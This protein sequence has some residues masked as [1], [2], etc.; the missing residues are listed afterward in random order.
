[1][2]TSFGNAVSDDLDEQ[3]NPQQGNIPGLVTHT[4]LFCVIVC[5]SFKPYADL[6]KRGQDA[7]AHATSVTD[8]QENEPV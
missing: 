6:F 2:S 7:H 4:S 1:M 8:N 3:T 5:I